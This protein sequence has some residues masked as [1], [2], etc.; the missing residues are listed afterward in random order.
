[1]TSSPVTHI[2]LCIIIPAYKNS[3]GGAHITQISGGGAL[4][5]MQ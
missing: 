5:D 2:P 3:Y 4:A 1:L